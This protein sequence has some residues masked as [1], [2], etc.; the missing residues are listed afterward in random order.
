MSR[1]TLLEIAELAERQNERFYAAAGEL[2]R[3]V[4]AANAPPFER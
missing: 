4:G 1:E 3:R 2:K